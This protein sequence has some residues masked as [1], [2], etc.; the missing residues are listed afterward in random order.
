MKIQKATMADL[1]GILSLQYLAY[2]SEAKLLNNPDIPPLKQTLD[3]VAMEFANGLILKAVE[4]DGSLLGSVRGYAKAGTLHIGKLIVR[5]DLQGQGI[6]SALMREIESLSAAGR[7]ELFTS[8]KSVRNIKL[9]E[10]LGYRIF[11]ED[12]Q[13]ADLAFVYMEKTAE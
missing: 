10:R 11:K 13:T 6:G 7:F 5:P 4:E 8:S 1:P 2:Q 3:E 9:Y 12:R